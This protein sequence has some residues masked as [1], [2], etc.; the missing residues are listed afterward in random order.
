M[1]NSLYHTPKF[2]TFVTKFKLKKNIK[3]QLKFII[4]KDN[5]NPFI[6]DGLIIDAA[7]PWVY[8]EKTYHNYHTKIKMIVAINGCVGN[9]DN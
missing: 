4:L 1:G 8:M 2:M 7:R 5:N 6:N 9:V 3:F